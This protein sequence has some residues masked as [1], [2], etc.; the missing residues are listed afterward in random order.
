MIGFNHLGQIGRL[1]NQMFQCAGLV[2]IA[3]KRGFEYCIPD[4]SMHHDYGGY[5]YHEL[6]SCFKMGDFENRYGYVDGNIVQLDQYHFCEELL[7]ECPDDCTLVGYFE[8][9]KYFKHIED[10]IRKNYQFLDSIVEICYNYGRDYLKD[11]PVGLVVRRGDFLAEHNKNR[12]S[13]CSIE[14]YQKSLEKFKG[15]TVLVFSDD[16]PWCKSQEIFQNK[17]T[18]F[19][20]GEK[21]IFKGHFDMCLLT[22]CSDFIIANS[23]FSWWGAWLSSNKEKKVIAPQKWYGPELQHLILKDQLP[24]NWERV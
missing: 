13:V 14:Y 3:E 5:Q 16:I 8:S 1:G 7:E 20:D 10:K 19:I 24:D 11:N 4:H 9:E 23:T 15:R 22:M 21:E 2:G 18:F 12:H 17:N 6:Q